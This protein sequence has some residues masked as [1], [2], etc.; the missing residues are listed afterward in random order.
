MSYMP[1]A[2]MC[3][4]MT[5]PPREDTQIPDFYI[6]PSNHKLLCFQHNSRVLK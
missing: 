3:S 4:Q 5:V 1:M 2:Y 6:S